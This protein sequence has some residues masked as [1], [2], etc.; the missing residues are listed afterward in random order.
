[1]DKSID[2]SKSGMV[3]AE[4]I[5]VEPNVRLHLTDIGEEI[6]PGIDQFFR[7]EGG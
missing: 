7:F 4:Y 2:K 1:M 5:E 3:I 6:H